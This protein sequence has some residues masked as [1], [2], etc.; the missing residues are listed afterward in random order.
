MTHFLRLVTASGL[1]DGWGTCP[2]AQFP[3]QARAGMTLLECAPDTVSREV[4]DGRTSFSVSLGWL[5][6]ALRARIDT[7]AGDLFKRYGTSI[8][9]QD[10]RYLLKQQ[11][12][13]AWTDGDEIAHPD[14]YPFMIAEAAVRSGALDP[15]TVA[16]VR[17]GIMAQVVAA[18]L[19]EAL[20]EAHRVTRKLAI[21]S[22][23]TLAEALA[24]ASVDWSAL[25]AEFE[26]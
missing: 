10:R 25:L 9:G 11:E 12:A 24:A 21:S 4:I 17:A 2:P 16:D 20:L 7:E 19:P 13:L 18:T 3:A 5:K 6:S 26:L 22:A 23:A 15:V 14:R 1:L 8:A